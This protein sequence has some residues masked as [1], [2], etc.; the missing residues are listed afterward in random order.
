MHLEVH[1]ESGE[2]FAFK[3]LSKGLLR[4][5]KSNESVVREKGI[6]AMCDSP[7]IV[8][9]KG[10]FHGEVDEL[11]MLSEVCLGG[12]LYATYHK[13][14]G[15][16]GSLTKARFYIGCTVLAL[17]YLHNKLDVMYRDLKPENLLLTS[18]GYCKMTDMGMAKEM[19]G[20]GERAELVTGY[21][22]KST[23]MANPGH[24]GSTEELSAR[25]AGLACAAWPIQRSPG[26]TLC[27]LA[28]SPSPSAAVKMPP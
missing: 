14:Y 4:K 6:L 13:Y 25:P 22:G 17:E 21:T 28:C 11:V 5:N 23:N 3:S 19:L 16:K 18:G 7:F 15:F 2:T 12:E 27:N 8:K 24:A 9:F 20:V 10:C 26:S 1:P